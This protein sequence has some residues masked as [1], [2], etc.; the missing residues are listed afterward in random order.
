MA[1]IVLTDM[2]DFCDKHRTLYARETVNVED[3]KKLLSLYVNCNSDYIV[4]LDNEVIY[5]S[6]HSQEAVEAYNEWS[7]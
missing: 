2:F 3:S 6:I 4:R 5:D 7:N 1:K